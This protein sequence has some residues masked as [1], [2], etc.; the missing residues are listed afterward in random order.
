M[1]RVEGKIE[2]LSEILN[3]LGKYG[4]KNLQADRGIIYLSTIVPSKMDKD[5]VEKLEELECEYSAHFM[6]WFINT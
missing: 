4:E 1:E 3:I 2:K 5:D 6:K